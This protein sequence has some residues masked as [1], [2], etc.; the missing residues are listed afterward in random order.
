MEIEG[1]KM[2]TDGVEMEIG[3]WCRCRREEGGKKKQALADRDSL[4][5]WSNTRKVSWSNTCK[6]SWSNTCK[7][8]WSNTV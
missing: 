4:R 7:V 1:V 3:A 8:S 5:C 2:D 6:V